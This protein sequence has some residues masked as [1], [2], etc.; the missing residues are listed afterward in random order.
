VRAVLLSALL[1]TCLPA[2]AQE[3]L[4]QP[5]CPRGPAALEA[6]VTV[7]FAAMEIAY[8]RAGED[9]LRET[10]RHADG[11]VWVYLSHPSGVVFESW[12]ERPD[13]SPD[14]DTRERL[15]W[16]FASGHPPDPAPGTNW[17]AK[18]VPEGGDAS[19]VAFTFGPVRRIEIGGC[20]YDAIRVT[21]TRTDL[22]PAADPPWINHIEHLP[23]LGLSIYLGGGEL[24]ATPEL[25]TPVAIS[26]KP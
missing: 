12:A 5:A 19:L 4:A 8:R 9:R 22:G 2:F 7:R 24:G 25:E 16:D 3:A 21:E 23:E 17:I 6:G 14:E 20:A 11:E 26:G 10:E 18:E 15:S 1:G 13:G